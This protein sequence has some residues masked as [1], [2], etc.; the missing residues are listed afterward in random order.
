[1]AIRR[2]TLIPTAVEVLCPYCGEP[3]VAPSNG[4][5]TMWCLGVGDFGPGDDGKVAACNACDKPMRIEWTL[6]K[7]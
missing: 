1:M 4:S 2:A 5:E 3:Q 6:K 7:P